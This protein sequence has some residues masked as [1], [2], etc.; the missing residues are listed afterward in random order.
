M[1]DVTIEEEERKGASARGVLFV[2]GTPIGE[3]RDM[4]QRAYAT[5]RSVD[6]VLAEDTRTTMAFSAKATPG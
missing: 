4:A 5:L 1:L 2:V 3:R 6:L